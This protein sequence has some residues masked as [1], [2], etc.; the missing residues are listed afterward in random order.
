LSVI[1][2]S[3]VL[4]HFNFSPYL[5]PVPLTHTVPVP[6]LKSINEMSDKVNRFVADV[7]SL[8]EDIRDGIEKGLVEK[9]SEWKQRMVSNKY[10]IKE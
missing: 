4:H 6:N 3:S 9:I 7:Q 10:K 1:I 5:P 2:I 8:D